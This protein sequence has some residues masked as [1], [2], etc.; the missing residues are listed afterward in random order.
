MHEH[1]AARVLD[2]RQRPVER[3]VAAAEDHHV[4]IRVCARILDAI[5]DV[6]AFELGRARHVEL[7][8]LERAHAA[9]DHDGAGIEHRA[10]AGHDAEAAVLLPRDFG[11]F[12]AEMQAR[13]ERP[14]LLEQPIGQLLARAHRH[15][16]NVVDR[17]VGIQLDALAAGRL[18][19]IDDLRLQAEQPELEYLEQAARPGADDDDVRL[20]RMAL[21]PKR[22]V[23]VRRHE[24]SPWQ[25]S[26]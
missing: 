7:A 13:A 3:G 5:V 18:Q 16:R 11:D 10:R 22:G 25:Q 6:L 20:D 19:R 23:G 14:D 26:P 17:L 1:D 21:E 8:R 9:R 4:L 2:E 15:G 12:L 24:Q